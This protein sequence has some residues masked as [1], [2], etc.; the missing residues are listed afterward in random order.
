MLELTS[1]ENPTK[2]YLTAETQRLEEEEKLIGEE[3]NQ[4]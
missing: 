2:D 3:T 1:K 4:I